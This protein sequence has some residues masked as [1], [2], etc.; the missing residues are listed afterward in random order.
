M[1][2]PIDYGKEFLDAYFHKQNLEECEAH[3]ADDLIW[4]TARQVRHL[5][6]AAE[7]RAFLE[8]ELEQHK[9]P[10]HIDIISIKMPPGPRE[11]FNISY[12]CNIIPIESAKATFLRVGLAVRPVRDRQQILFVSF[13]RKYEN[14]EELREENK[15]L[16]EQISAL[17]TSNAEKL[18]S[19]AVRHEEELRRLRSESEERLSNL[20]QASEEHTRILLKEKELMQVRMAAENEQELERARLDQAMVEG[21]LEVAKARL[22]EKEKA[23]EEQLEQEKQRSKEALEELE[24]KHQE[25]LQLDRAEIRNELDAQQKQ[26]LSEYEEAYEEQKNALERSLRISEEERASLTEELEK[27]RL[28]KEEAERTLKEE[29]QQK[30][31]VLEAEKQAQLDALNAENQARG[32]ALEAESKE[33]IGELENDLAQTRTTLEEALKE[34]ERLRE[35]AGRLERETADAKRTSDNAVRARRENEELLE[36][37]RLEKD[38]I[39][40]ELKKALERLKFTIRQNEE[41]HGAAEKAAAKDMVSMIGALAA[42]MKPYEKKFSLSSCLDVIE[43]YAEE[44]CSSRNIALVPFERDKRL[45]ESVRGDKACLQMILLNLIGY[46]A[47]QGSP[48]ELSEDDPEVRKTQDRRSIRVRVEAERP[49]RNKVYLKFRIQDSAD[50][51]MKLAGSRNKDLLYTQALLGMMGG[52]VQVR[53]NDRGRTEAVVT[54]NLLMG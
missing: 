3:L 32:D 27:L 5:K 20:S 50:Q 7:R 9:G 34:A 36:R 23:F 51:V 53:R 41:N 2:T 47:A 11:C 30:Q 6:T 45:P 44:D 15:A 31:E 43:L 42:D 46:I 33:K 49:V 17:T 29:A 19:Q 14:A 35:H 54:V 25:R 13:S 8:E 38:Q 18:K 26:I 1:I 16:K 39:T 4:V 24:L 22:E 37:S 40:E 48:S 21:Q 12:E 28:E 10:C 52:G